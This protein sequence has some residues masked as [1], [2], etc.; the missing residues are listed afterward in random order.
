MFNSPSGHSY[1]A[2]YCHFICGEKSV[3]D[4]SL[5][6]GRISAAFLLLSHHVECGM[7][8]KQAFSRSAKSHSDGK[9]LTSRIVFFFWFVLLPDSISFFMKIETKYFW[10]VQHDRTLLTL[11]RGWKAVCI[12][13]N[14]AVGAEDQAV[15]LLLPAPGC[16]TERTVNAPRLTHQ[17]NHQLHASVLQ[18]LWNNDTVTLVNFDMLT[19]KVPSKCHCFS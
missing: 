18:Y 7:G 16:C 14:S 15:P 1:M 13:E 6:A 5:A 10:T 11:S 17:P 3:L 2:E 19:L 12:P 8:F 9:S 4:I